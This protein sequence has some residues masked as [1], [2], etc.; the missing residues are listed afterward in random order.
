MG[1]LIYLFGLILMITCAL[2]PLFS[3]GRKKLINI[4]CVVVPLA[5]M[6]CICTFKSLN[7]GSDTPVY[8]ESY[9][10]AYEVSSIF[11]ARDIGYGILQFICAR[12]HLPWI[13]F[14]GICN[15]PIFVGTAI[16]AFKKTPH[17]SFMP[18]F[19]YTFLIFEFALSGLRQS[20]ATGFIF[21]ALAFFNNKKWQSWIIYYAFNA[22]AILMHKT[23]FVMLVIPLF[24]F[25]K[26]SKRSLFYATA[27]LLLTIIFIPQI[28]SYFYYGT[29]I[30]EYYPNNQTTNYTFVFVFVLIYMIAI[31]I[32][33]MNNQILKINNWIDKEMSKLNFFK[34][35]LLDEKI[36]VARNELVL[37]KEFIFVLPILIFLIIGLYSNTAV[38]GYYYSICS[39]GLIFIYWI[40]SQKSKYTRFMMFLSV[41][42][43]FSLY[44]VFTFLRRSDCVPYKFFF[45]N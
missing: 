35:S 18:F 40:Y 7:I 37:K 44:F 29:N 32:L 22:L 43:L 4:L 31:S 38:R 42:I 1:I 12:M 17:P 26:L 28:E 16:F 8:Y 13:V 27:I 33:F 19:I 9:S 21:I 34:K 23:S 14:L 10:T 25:I 11:K 24:S 45:Q 2:L 20:I 41:V 3:F 6:W 30:L 39:F 15:L 36:D 5:F